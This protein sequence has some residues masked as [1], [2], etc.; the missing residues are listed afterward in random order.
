[1][2]RPRP[3]LPPLGLPGILRLGL[4]QAALGGIVMLVTSMLNRI[5]VVEYA[6]PAVLPAA[7]IAWHYAVQLS[8]PGFG[9]ASDQGGSRKRFILGGMALLAL[10][11]LTATNAVFV[12]EA[13]RVA[14]LLAAGLGFA[15]IGAGVGAAGTSL[16]A[17]LASRVEPGRRPLAAATCWIMMVA[18][19]AVTAGVAGGFIDP[20]S[21]ER[22][23]MVA[24]TICA[25]ALGVTVLATRGVAE[26]PP[27]APERGPESF[28]E[29]LQA[30]WGDARVRGFTLF[31]LVSMLAYAMQDVILEPFAG[32][33]FGF[34]PGES[35]R[36]SSIQH[37]ATLAGM[38]TVGLAG[39][40]LAARLP[41]GSRALVVAGCLL[42]AGAL[43]LLA[44]GARMG[45]GFPL[46]ATAALL[47]FG[48]GMFAVAAIAAMMD[49]AG[50]EGPGREGIR[51]GLWGAAQAV[52]FA[53][54][55][56]VGAAGVDAGRTLLGDDAAA[57]AIVFAGEAL[58]FM[59]AAGLALKVHMS[60]SDVPA[61]AAGVAT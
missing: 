11:A 18:G 29:G 26:G 40:W 30:I 8:R 51:M 35:T 3:P 28:A 39:R 25:V 56:L 21:P 27:V 4:V 33:V 20:F 38:L 43:A 41:G 45:E 52:A 42:S 32:L 57:F 6:L 23:A 58:L 16:L 9:H 59:G 15:M 10:G 24:G 50:I 61:A 34:S 12:M 60:R 47:G 14:G 7:L 13:Y 22:L 1:M 19:I 17:L 48:N 49:L 55:G 54:G 37:G 31:V 36:L 44:L 46:R 5:M 2:S 53:L